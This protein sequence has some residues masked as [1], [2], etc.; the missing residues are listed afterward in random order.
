MRP[1]DNKEAAGLQAYPLVVHVGLVAHE[2]LVDA[3]RGVLL[4]ALH[5]DLDVCVHHRKQGSPPS[6]SRSCTTKVAPQTQRKGERELDER[7]D[8]QGE[9]RRRERTA[10]GV[11]VGDVVDK[12]HTVT[13][14][15]VSS[16]DGACR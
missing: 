10:E 8:T 5:P 14:T 12:H 15:V 2:D 13:A 3:L 16:G 1:R 11:L 7:R 4:N 6:V 9:G